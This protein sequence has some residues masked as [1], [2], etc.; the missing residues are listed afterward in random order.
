M[1]CRAVL[2]F[3][4]RPVSTLLLLLAGACHRGDELAPVETLTLPECDAGAPPS[5]DC[6]SIPD[7]GA[8]DCPGGLKTLP[9]GLSLQ[10]IQGSSGDAACSLSVDVRVTVLQPATMSCAATWRWLNNCLFFDLACMGAASSGAK[11]PHTYELEVPSLPAG[12]SWVYTPDGSALIHQVLPPGTYCE[13]LGCDGWSTTT[14]HGDA[15]AP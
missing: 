13:N 3:D 12:T 2:P 11:A 7:L 14:C 5:V 10:E 15:G 8:P 6:R 1:P 4:P 9:A